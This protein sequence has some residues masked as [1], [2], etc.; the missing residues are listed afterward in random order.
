MLPETIAGAVTT[1]LLTYTLVPSGCCFAAPIDP[2]DHVTVIVSVAVLPHTSTAVMVIGLSPP[3]NVIFCIDHVDGE[4]GKLVNVPVPLPPL[5]LYQVM[6]LSLAQ[7]NSVPEESTK[8]A[9]PDSE[10]EPAIVAKAGLFVG[11]KIEAE[12]YEGAVTV[13]VSSALLPHISVAVTVMILSPPC[14]VTFLRDQEAGVNNE[15]VYVP[16]PLPPLLFDHAMLPR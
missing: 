13:I 8:L 14:K 11:C 4:V 5:P 2:G 12:R 15:L 1:A 16:V 6:E 9:I 7:F 3:C 10:T